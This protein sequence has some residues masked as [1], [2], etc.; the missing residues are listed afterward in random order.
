M[1][2]LV[3]IASVFVCIAA[4]TITPRIEFEAPEVYPEGVAYDSIGKIYYVSSARLGTIGKVSPQ[5][6]YTI[7]YSD[8]SLKSSYGLKISPDGKRLYAC[9]G[10]A[11]YSKFKSAETDKKMARLIGIDLKTGKKMIDTDLSKLISGK[12]FGN[13]LTFDKTGNAYITDSFANAIYKVSP[14]GKPSVFAQHDLFKSEGVSLN[15]IVCHPTGFLIVANGGTGSLLKVDLKNPSNVQKVK[16]DQFF[17]NADGLLLDGKDLIMVQN[18]GVNKIY[19]FQ[20]TDNW[21]SAKVKAATGPDDHFMFPSTATRANN[22]IWVVNAKFNELV[23]STN[24]PSKKF[25]LQ[26]AIFKPVP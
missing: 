9:V 13:D 25:T 4:A 19:R 22:E 21:M 8:N 10:D 26:K 20:S 14:D 18:G 5:G 11:N 2:K 24:V 1:K 3:L 23:D 12:H 6:K 7:F 17:M 15:G 16:T